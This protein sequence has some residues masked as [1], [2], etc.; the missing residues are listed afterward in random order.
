MVIFTLKSGCLLVQ[1]EIVSGEHVVRL[2]DSMQMLLRD[3]TLHIDVNVDLP[4]AELLNLNDMLLFSHCVCLS[5]DTQL[6][7][8]VRRKRMQMWPGAQKPRHSV[9][10][11]AKHICKSILDI[12]SGYLATVCLGT[13]SLN[14]LCNFS[15][16]QDRQLLYDGESQHAEQLT[17]TFGAGQPFMRDHRHLPLPSRNHS[18]VVPADLPDSLCGRVSFTFH[19]QEE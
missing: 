12:R 3:V 7:P 1:D 15:F 8:E 2:E 10:N 6:D 5:T 11:S 19:A 4:G 18:A 16:R 14:R 9:P 17:G 13:A